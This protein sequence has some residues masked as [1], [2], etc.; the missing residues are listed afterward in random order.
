VLLCEVHESF[1]SFIV[2]LVDCSNRR[3]RCSVGGKRDWIER[4]YAENTDGSGEPLD[5][6]HDEVGLNPPLKFV[7]R[8][9]T[10]GNCVRR[11]HPEDVWIV[12]STSDDLKYWYLMHPNKS[13]NL[14]HP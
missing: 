4:V 11:L 12:P 7:W 13:F 1:V 8:V 6:D 2:F 5:E 14:Q 3:V 10:F 9:G